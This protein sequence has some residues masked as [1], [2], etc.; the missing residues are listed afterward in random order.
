MAMA[1]RV[2]LWSR[3]ANRLLLA[4]DDRCQRPGQHLPALAGLPWEDWLPE[5]G[6]FVVDFSGQSESIR[7]TRFG[8]QR[9]KD[10]IVDRFRERGL[11]GHR[12][13]QNR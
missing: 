12:S 4:I 11:P 8:A 9:A 5:G 13:T 7:N 6:S 1:Y 2:A 10:A 3:L